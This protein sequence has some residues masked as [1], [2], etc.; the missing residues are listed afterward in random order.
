MKRLLAVIA[1]LAVLGVLGFFALA[2]RPAIAPIIP[3]PPGSFAP[4]LVAKGEALSGGGFCADMPHC[5][6]RAEIRW[7][8]RD[9]DALRRDLLDQHHSRS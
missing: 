2:W 8:L 6:R 5:Q 3:P 4:E 1:G 9:A 7:R